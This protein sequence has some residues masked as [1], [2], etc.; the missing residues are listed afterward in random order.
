MAAGE[1][2]LSKVESEVELVVA[3]DEDK[4]GEVAEED[5]KNFDNKSDKSLKSCHSSSSEDSIRRLNR[6]PTI[7]IEEP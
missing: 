3:E 6:T 2:N 4:D 1:Q 7:M 5:K